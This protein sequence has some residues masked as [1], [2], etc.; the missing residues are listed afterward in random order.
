MK[1]VKSDL[2]LAVQNQIIN[3]EQA[4]NL[5]NYFESLRPDQARFQA[6]HALYYL[7]GMLVFSSMFWFLTIA[8]GDGLEI[9]IVSG[10]FAMLYV[11]AGNELLNKQN[12]EIPACLLI[13]SAVGLVPVFIFGFQDFMGLWPE[14]MQNNYFDYHTRIRSNWLL[15]ELST[16]VAALIALRFYQFTFVTFP[17]AI[18][19]WYM[20]MDLAPFLFGVDNLTFEERKLVSCIFGFFVMVCSYFVDKKFKRTDFA[21]WTYLSGMLAF[22]V[23]LSMMDSNSEISKFVYFLLNL[24][25]IILSLYL[26]RKVFM[27][28]GVIGVF[29]YLG[30]LAWEVFKHSHLFPL[31]MIMVGL[32]IMFLGTKYQ[33][34]KIRIERAA[35]KLFPTFLNKWRPEERC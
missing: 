11:K 13:T 14:G 28:F 35:E 32:G 33:Q 21:F 10:L 22:W 20:S 5:W 2:Q 26:R 15:M 30:H 29:G 24:F 8:W 6:L 16:V 31:T 1:I 23:G 25:F 19:L 34:N 27:V 17:L 9:M 12:L 4:D 18:T 3:S 7:G